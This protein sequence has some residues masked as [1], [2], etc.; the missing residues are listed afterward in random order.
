[1]C[2]RGYVGLGLV[3]IMLAITLVG[4]ASAHVGS[5]A[6]RAAADPA[7]YLVSLGL[8]P[9]GFIVQ[10][11]RRNY[12]GPHCPGKGWTC[13]KSKRVLQIATGGNSNSVTCTATGGSGSKSASATSSTASCTIVQTSTTGAN[14]ATCTEQWT[15]SGGG[16][17]TQ[18]C[19]ITQTSA[20]GANTANVTQTLQEGPASCSPPAG[21]SDAQTEKGT[22]SASVVQSS[23]AGAA[24]ANV[25]QTAVTVRFD[26]HDGRGLAEPDDRPGVHDPAGAVGFDPSNPTGCDA[27]TGVLGATATQSQ[28]ERGY[29]TSAS[30]GAQTQK[31]DLIG[32]VDQCSVDHADYSA[33]QFEDQIPRAERGGHADADRADAADGQARSAARG[34]LAPEV[35]LL[36]LPG[37][38]RHRFLHDHP[39]DEPDR[40][41][42]PIANQTEDISSQAGTSGR[43]T[44]TISGNQNTTTFGTDF[45]GPDLHTSVSCS[46]QVCTGF[47]V[48]TALAWSGDASGTYHDQATLAATLTRTDNGDR[49]SGQAV[50]LGVGAE[51]CS[52]TTDGSGNASCSVTLGDTPG[53]FTASA[54][55]DRNVELRGELG[56]RRLHGEQGADR[57]TYQG[58]SHAA[59]HD[60]VTLS[61]DPR[62]D[63][64]PS[65]GV[66]GRIG[67][68]RAWR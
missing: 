57:L 2:G 19:T 59:Y 15:A 24:N 45:T 58:P 27:K 54:N 7:R 29:A 41:P 32:H 1:M 56:E 63:H 44:G 8:D 42:D 3:V 21:T 47:Q 62:R 5:T 48:P 40:E 50:T 20:S 49:I 67:H 18:T 22:Q 10:H 33:S 34:S 23:P 6:D 55:F 65:V 52:A 14:S 31:A 37:Q 38:Q 46:S 17:L 68:L 25:S 39:D 53:P 64:H 30:S 16:P 36:Q 60:T 35:E 26:D 61:A 12:A 9:T 43:C 11:G 4:G 13:T 66:G 51:S 28:H